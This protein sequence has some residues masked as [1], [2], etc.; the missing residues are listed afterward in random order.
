MIIFAFETGV[1]TFEK[2]SDVKIDIDICHLEKE[3]KKR[4]FEET[5]KNR[6]VRIRKHF[7]SKHKKK[8]KQKRKD[9]VETPVIKRS[10]FS[11]E[12]T[13]EHNEGGRLDTSCTP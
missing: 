10:R 9:E 2:S 5:K 12:I 11:P 7:S 1:L 4:K 8:K 6:S 3:K 13:V